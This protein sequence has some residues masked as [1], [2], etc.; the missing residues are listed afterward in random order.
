MKEKGVLP[1][2]RKALRRFLSELGAYTKSQS[3]VPAAGSPAHR[4]ES[5]PRP[6]SA[7]TA[8]G[9]AVTLAELAAE[10]AVLLAD[11]LEAPAKPLACVSC[12]RT[13]LENTSYARWILDREI[14][15]AER[16]ERVFGYKYRGLEQRL[17]SA[18][19][20]DVAVYKKRVE[21]L[22]HAATELNVKVSRHGDGK[23]DL[24]GARRSATDLCKLYGGEETYRLL[25]AIQ[26]GHGWAIR[27]WCY[28]PQSQKIED[29]VPVMRF[30]KGIRRERLEFLIV[31]VVC[32]LSG[33][34][35]AMAD[36]MGW[37][38]ERLEE[39]GRQ[40]LPS[41]N[42]EEWLAGTKSL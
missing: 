9:I 22:V 8:Y 12:A 5:L 10:N 19:S 13:V 16:V 4:E 35:W 14:E 33:A 11:A 20:D 17:K 34:V 25:S 38:R 2:E 26:H 31:T 6:V 3:D 7:R 24:V 15:A 32:G 36:F 42:F 28:V 37:D 41:L 23:L 27:R 30:S 29:G 21:E 18:G 40:V 39:I 1:K